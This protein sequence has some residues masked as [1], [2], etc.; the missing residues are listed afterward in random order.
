MPDP[1]P[2]SEAALEPVPGP[3]PAASPEPG[4]PTPAEVPA[5]IP[6]KPRPSLFHHPNFRKLWVGDTI[7]QFG[8]QVSQLAIPLVAI[9]FLNA[10]PFEVALLGTVEFLPFLLFT[11]PAGAWV[12]R[13]H[14]RPILIIG[15]LG[16]A[17]ALASIPVAYALGTLTI[18]QL[19]VVG[20]AMGILTVFFDVSYQ[21]YLPSL[22]DRDQ[23]VEG[24]AKLQASQ[25]A[26]QIVGPGL[27]GY[28][29]GVLTAP[30]AV[31]V[32]AASYLASALFVFSIRGSEAPIPPRDGSPTGRVERVRAFGG[33]IR[34][35]LAFVVGHPYLRMI[36]G[37]TSTS[38]LFGNIATGILLVYVVRVLLLDPLQ[39][40]LVFSL[41]SIGAFAGALVAN[42][43]A[44]R[45]GVGRTIVAA[46][47]LNGPATLLIAIAPVAN[48]MPFLV[49][50]VAL[51]SFTGLVYNINQV[52]FRQAI[53][54][55]RMQ[56]RMNAT[57]RFL[58]WGTIPIG[59]VLSG[60]LATLFGLST[61]IWIGAILSFTPVLFLVF[62]S[63]RT[64]T[65]MPTSPDDWSARNVALEA[66]AADEM[67][68]TPLL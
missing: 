62:S 13:L 11:L 34:E 45:I 15:D 53:T 40:G 38:N 18:A 50:S 14:R 58:V 35:G 26:A 64:I 2:P 52:S 4:P 55:E 43:I 59:S 36:A 20:F 29:I 63:V 8:T 17:L 46:M 54:P 56:G 9:L 49:A 61:T 1:E 22:V 24:N 33:E 41:G 23:L 37:A 25:S 57:M 6:A 32:D 7:S 12:D 31:I 16:R 60:I 68:R 47:A 51:G 10:T 65:T 21:S 30:I 42:L 67:G 44:A 48:P 5:A 39:I 27:G 66:A 28:V 3:G 19:Y